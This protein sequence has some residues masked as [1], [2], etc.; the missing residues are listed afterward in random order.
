MAG[1]KLAATD[2]KNLKQSLSFFASAREWFKRAEL[3]GVDMSEQFNRIE[4]NE[5][6]VNSAI[7]SFENAKESPL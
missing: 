5:R 2:V 4:A 7:A 6:I 1:P 3:F